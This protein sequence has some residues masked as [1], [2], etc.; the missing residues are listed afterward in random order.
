MKIEESVEL[1][2]FLNKI[3]RYELNKL[4][5]CIYGCCDSFSP[6]TEVKIAMVD[7]KELKDYA[8]ILLFKIQEE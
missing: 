7:E 1:A 8:Q 2:N 3:D 5:A 6:D 4:L